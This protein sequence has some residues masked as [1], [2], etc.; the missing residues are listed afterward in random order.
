MPGAT[1]VAPGPADRTP[2]LGGYTSALELPAGWLAE[3]GIGPDLA[4]EMIVTWQM[5]GK[6]LL[7][8][9]DGSGVDRARVREIA[10][11]TWDELAGPGP[12]RLFR[13]QP[14]RSPVHLWTARSIQGR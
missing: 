13:R 4:D 11:A 6:A 7:I 1:V 2:T 14:S 5:T 9:I 8:V 10:D 3:V 12:A